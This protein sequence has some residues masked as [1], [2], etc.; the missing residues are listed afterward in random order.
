MMLLIRKV[1]RRFQFEKKRGCSV[2]VLL[3]CV[4]TPYPQDPEARGEGSVLI[5]TNLR[6]TLT[7]KEDGSPTQ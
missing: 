7:P 2:K 3:A 1:L 6:M 5:E 4:Q